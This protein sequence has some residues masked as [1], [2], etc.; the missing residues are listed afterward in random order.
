MY[1]Y[2]CEGTPE[3]FGGAMASLPIHLS[4]CPL[5]YWPAQEKVIWLYRSTLS[6]LRPFPIDTDAQISLTLCW[7]SY[8]I[9]VAI[10]GELMASE[11]DLPGGRSCSI[12]IGRLYSMAC[13]T[14]GMRRLKAPTARIRE[15]ERT[16]NYHCRPNKLE[17]FQQPQDGNDLV[18]CFYVTLISEKFALS[19][20]RRPFHADRSSAFTYSTEYEETIVCPV[21]Q[22]VSITTRGMP[23]CREGE[24]CK[25][26][27]L[28]PPTAPDQ[29]SRCIVW[30]LFRVR[31]DK[32]ILEWKRR[33]HFPSLAVLR[34]W[35][36]GDDM[37]I[38]PSRRQ[39]LNFSIRIWSGEDCRD[40]RVNFVL[41]V[42]LL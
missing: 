21:L 15:V 37:L 22:A 3:D 33:F 27:G 19:Q 26:D 34:A 30:R 29:R 32:E 42:D 6:L 28:R 8:S 39:H 35:K 14:D 24:C 12:D 36:V 20:G 1:Q 41:N 25:L 4:T 17:L 31:R 7:P 16:D 2:L 9:L 11:G 40:S 13:Q 18:I 23:Y 5:W 38:S 10:S